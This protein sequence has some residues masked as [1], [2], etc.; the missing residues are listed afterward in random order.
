M[1]RCLIS[2]AFSSLS[3]YLSHLIWGNFLQEYA[4]HLYYNCIYNRLPNGFVNPPSCVSIRGPA[5]RVKAR[6]RQV[7]R[8]HLVAHYSAPDTGDPTYWWDAFRAK[9]N[10]LLFCFCEVV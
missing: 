9:H 10:P 7:H 1:P 5:V 8:G 4:V 3:S 2:A 6:E